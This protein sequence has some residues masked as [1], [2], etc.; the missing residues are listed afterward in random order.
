M[1]KNDSIYVRHITVLIVEEQYGN[2]AIVGIQRLGPD[3]NTFNLSRR[4]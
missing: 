4:H 1:S 3:L 2:R